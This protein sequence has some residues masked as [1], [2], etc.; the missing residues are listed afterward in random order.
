L[1]EVCATRSLQASPTPNILASA[2]C[3]VQRGGSAEARRRY[4][5]SGAGGTTSVAPRREPAETHTADEHLDRILG[6]LR[7]VG[8]AGVA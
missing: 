2:T 4:N 7:K 6:G 8:Q 1:G 3:G 5:E